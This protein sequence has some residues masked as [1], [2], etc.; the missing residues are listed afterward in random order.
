MESS[1]KPEARRSGMQMT[2]SRRRRPWSG[3]SRI[4]C[5]VYRFSAS[6]VCA[7]STPRY[8]DDNVVRLKRQAVAYAP[9][10]RRRRGFGS[11]LNVQSRTVEF[12]V[13]SFPRS[14]G[15]CFEISLITVWSSCSKET[16]LARICVDISQRTP[17]TFSIPTNSRFLMTD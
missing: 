8:S 13:P 3:F 5:E 10:R 1:R 4:H 6:V 7:Y 14:S 17:V 2:S 9:L 16:T 12:V 11:L 15:T